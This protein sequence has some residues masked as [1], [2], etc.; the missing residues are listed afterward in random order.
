MPTDAAFE[1][2]VPYRHSVGTLEKITV[3]EVGKGYDFRLSVTAPGGPGVSVYLEGA[4][5]DG[6]IDA[7]LDLKDACE[8]RQH[9]GRPIL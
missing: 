1:C 2:V 7:L 4:V 3:A 6:L 8:R 5:L 9:H